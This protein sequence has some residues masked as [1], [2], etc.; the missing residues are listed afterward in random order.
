MSVRNWKIGVKLSL[1]FGAL[2]LVFVAS[3]FVTWWYVNAVEEE[4]IFL[5][6]RVVPAMQATETLNRQAY[7]LFLTMRDMQYTETDASIAAA[8]T[9]LEE[10][11]NQEIVVSAMYRAQPELRGPQHVAE[12]VVPV[13]KNYVDTFNRTLSMVSKKKVMLSAIGKTCDDV[14]ALAN[15]LA[16]GILAS[17]KRSLETQRG[18]ARSLADALRSI[19]KVTEDIM[20]L[21]RSMIMAMSS[22][23]VDRL[24]SSLTMMKGLQ[25]K[26]ESL[27]PLLESPEDK[28]AMESLTAAFAQYETEHNEF[29]KMYMGLLDI[30]KSL[31]PLMRNLN[32]EIA[33]ATDKSLEL[34]KSISKTG[35][36]DLVQALSVMIASTAAAV[37]FGILTAVFI[38]RGIS[39][40]LNTIVQLAKRAGSGDLTL[41]RKDFGYEGRDELGALVEALSNMIGAQEETMQEVVSVAANLTEGASSLSAISEETS[42]SMGEVKA[43]IDQVA[44]LSESNGS[45]LE[46][47]NAGVEEMSAGADTVAQSAT[48][49][50]A[51]IAQ[52]TEASNKAIQTVDEVIRGMRDVDANSKES[53]NKIKQLVASVE[54][55]GSFVSVITGIADQ[56][57]LL[58]LNAAIEA[59]RAGE[60]GRGFAV[61]AEEVRKLAEE[62]AN[63]AQ[64]VN[65]IIVELQSGAQESI[66]ATTE[67][68]HMLGNTLSQA[69]KAQKELN[70]A[71]KEMNKAND[72][73]QNIAA[74][75]EEQAASSREAA[76]AI[77]SATKSTMEMVDTITNIRRAAD[78]TATAAHGVA[79]QSEA[80]TSRA[81]ALADVLTRFKLRSRATAQLNAPAKKPYGMLPGKSDSNFR[82]KK[83]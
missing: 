50:A 54:N 2:L 31:N 3:G 11:L 69:E 1:G 28:K 49:S 60:V 79:Q 32:Y 65:K 35:V 16:D 70:A 48:D 82:A 29:T 73:I 53:E 61:V 44:A 55:V 4:S 23:D 68:A 21:R 8:K 15:A 5:A 43:S 59:A 83:A 51:F 19:G 46:E 74:V 24:K 77:D 66:K 52:T 27:K 62:S 20:S 76:T 41:E 56:T 17:L 57:N 39:K 18:D 72:S 34:V 14:A 12:V 6:E 75:A 37:G 63:A 38:A 7:E 80:M 22:N 30:Y 67:A 47:S 9:Q 64:S 26:V 36:K 13:A 81:Q 78:E 71:L 25:K 10:C 40:P 58:A 42:A 33:V 45:A